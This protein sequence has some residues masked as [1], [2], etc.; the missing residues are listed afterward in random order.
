MLWLVFEAVAVSV[1]P[2][3]VDFVVVATSEPQFSD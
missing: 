1:I 2:K 3:A